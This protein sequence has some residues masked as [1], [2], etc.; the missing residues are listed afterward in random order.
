MGE[1][2]IDWFIGPPVSLILKSTLRIS[3]LSINV[4]VLLLLAFAGH[5]LELISDLVEVVEEVFYQ[6]KGHFSL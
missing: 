2:W 4:Y 1:R 3:H 5:V 6:G